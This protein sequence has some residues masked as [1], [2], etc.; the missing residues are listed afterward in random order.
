MKIRIGTERARTHDAEIEY[1]ASS[2]CDGLAVDVRLYAVRKTG[3]RDRE[4]VAITFEREADR[5]QL[6]QLARRFV[7]ICESNGIA[8]RDE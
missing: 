6:A 8:W 3:T 1:S 4:R 7:A 2:H 5:E